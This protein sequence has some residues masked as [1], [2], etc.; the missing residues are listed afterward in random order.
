MTVPDVVRGRLT[1]EGFAVTEKSEAVWTLTTTLVEWDSEPELPVTVTVKLPVGVEDW[2]VTVSVAV[3]L[4]PEVRE[5]DDGFNETLGPLGE[6]FEESVTVPPNPPVLASVIV[7]DPEPPGTIWKVEGLE[8]MVKSGV[9]GCVTVTVWDAVAVA[10]AES[11]TWSWTVNEPE[12][13]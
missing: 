5:T 7:D 8:V 3:A 13:E 1:D 10:L 2:V 11:V 4:P 6:M 9:G 12:V